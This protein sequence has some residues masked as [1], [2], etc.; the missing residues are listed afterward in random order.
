MLLPHTL[1][2][3]PAAGQPLLARTP[4]L[5]PPGPLL[6]TSAGPASGIYHLGPR[7][8]FPDTLPPSAVPKPRSNAFYVHVRGQ[9]QDYPGFQWPKKDSSFS[10]PRPCPPRSA[11]NRGAG[12]IKRFQ[13]WAVIHAVL[14]FYQRGNWDP[15]GCWTF[16]FA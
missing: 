12:L 13:E 1:Q 2:L 7:R 11:A 8:P 14:S 6:V 15:K 9:V 16:S 10:L 5:C 4:T 3:P